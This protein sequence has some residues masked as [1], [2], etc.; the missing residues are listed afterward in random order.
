M[1]RE[2][3]I[4][5]LGSRFARTEFEKKILAFP[6][7]FE[8]AHFIDE[9]DGASVPGRVA[10]SVSLRDPESGYIGFFVLLGA[11]SAGGLCRMVSS[12]GF[13]SRRRVPFPGLP[14]PG[15]DSAEVPGS[16]RTGVEPGVFRT[17]TGFFSKPHP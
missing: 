8:R 13:Q 2:V 12:C 1:I 14:A 3:Q 15:S 4:Q 16:V 7:E 17:A 5:E 11:I 9:R 10:A 6:F